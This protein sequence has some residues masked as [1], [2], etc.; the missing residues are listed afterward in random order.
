MVSTDPLRSNTERD[1]AQLRLR[2]RK[3]HQRMNLASLQQRTMTMEQQIKQVEGPKK[4]EEMMDEILMYMAYAQMENKD[5]TLIELPPQD[6]GGSL[7]LLG[8]LCPDRN[9]N[10][11]K[12]GNAE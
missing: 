12:R 3:A 11:M 9:G 1:A 10:V 6:E 7:K 8:R 5:N 4:M 2:E